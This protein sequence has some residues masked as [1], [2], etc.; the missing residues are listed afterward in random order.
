MKKPLIFSLI[1]ISAALV[2][3]FTISA[4]E[5]ATKKEPGIKWLSFS[6]AAKL[7]AKQPKKIFIDVYTGWCGWCVKMDKTTFKDPKITQYINDNYY[8]V[9]LD[10]ESNTMTTYKGKAM[11]EMELAKNIFRATGFPTTVYLDEDQNLLQ[12]ISGY[13]EAEILDKILHFYGED[14]YKTMSWEQFQANYN[15]AQ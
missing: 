14:S 6:E 2:T 8:A 13:L 5:D 7:N 10:A 4:N 3:A 11:K 9:K 1:L 12:P 15:S